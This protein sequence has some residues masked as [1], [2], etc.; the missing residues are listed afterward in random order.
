[1]TTERVTVTAFGVALLFVVLSTWLSYEGMQDLISSQTWVA[2]THEVDNHLTLLQSNLLDAETG[3]RGFLFTSDPSYLEPYQ[4]AQL[5]TK[6]QL[7]VLRQLVSD[8]P[9]QERHLDVLTPLIAAKISELQETIKIHKSGRSKEA[10]ALVKSDRG[11][12]TMDDARTVI[13]QMRQEEQH[14]L[15]SRQQSARARANS[16][17]L[18][19]VGGSLLAFLLIAA[20]AA[21]IIRAIRERKQAYDQLIATNQKIEAIVQ[22]RT[23]ELQAASEKWRTTLSSIGDAVIATDA[24][25]RITFMN[26]VSQALTGWSEHDALQQPISNVFRI[27][28]EHTKLPL[29]SPITRVMQTGTV[30]GLAN[31]TLLVTREGQEIPIDDSGAPIRTL[32]GDIAGVILVFR[33][34]AERYRNEQALAASEMTLRLATESTKLGVWDY[35]PRIGTIKCDKR[36]REVLGLPPDEDLN[37]EQFLDRVYPEDRL[38]T[39]NAIR[40]ALDP[41]NLGAH[42]TEYRTIGPTGDGARWIAARG[43]VLFTETGQ[44]TRVLCTVL[45]ITDS[46]NAEDRLKQ[47]NIELERRIAERTQTLVIYQER[48]RALAA[49]LSVTEDRERRRLAAELHDY[50]AQLLVLCRIKIAQGKQHLHNGPMTEEM[51]GGIDQIVAQ[52]LTYTRSLIADLSPQVLYQFGLPRALAWLGDDMRR[53]GLTVDVVLA[54]ESIALT[55]D[56]AVLVYQSVRELLFNVIKHAGIDR[57]TVRLEESHQTLRI[58]VSDEGKGF[59]PDLALVGHDGPGSKFGLFNIRERLESIGGRLQIHSRDGCGT[60]TTI[61]V[62]LHVVV[63]REL[64]VTLH[65]VPGQTSGPV[66]RQGVGRLRILL[67][68]DHAM[69]R[70]GLRSVLEKYQDLEIVGEA[71]D[72]VEAINQAVHLEPEVVVMD[73]H[74][75]KL[76]GIQATLRILQKRPETIIVVISVQDDHQITE[77]VRSAGAMGFISKHSVAQELYQAIM[78][79]TQAAKRAPIGNNQ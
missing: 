74:M 62:P 18:L 29:E 45:D 32:A 59:D 34:I 72:G 65:P 56:R 55:D 42:A 75:P 11:K 10:L 19:L 41:A 12:R 63:Q 60:T 15:E 14:L 21:I 44:P 8:N 77:A 3:Q 48:L 51:L 17:F 38:F 31:H 50:L 20:S 16:M 46:K 27:I 47:S 1:M 64:P 57:A 67:V 53:H 7:H 61:E 37:Y 68:D 22:E 9:P 58:L 4:T 73:I 49:E 54:T 76:D 35:D 52:S 66:S 70:Q 78:Q 43:Q 23:N 71:A 13:A 5:R 40:S 28:N 6:N 2:H 39:Q 24:Q 30:V 25:G 69:V 26:A 79:A 33:D 36:C